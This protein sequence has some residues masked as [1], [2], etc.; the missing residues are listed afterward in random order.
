MYCSYVHHTIVILKHFQTHNAMLLF[1]W[2][3]T[4]V[5]EFAVIKAIALTT[6]NLTFLVNDFKDRKR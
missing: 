1:W 3:W 5:P 4:G 6:R 2:W